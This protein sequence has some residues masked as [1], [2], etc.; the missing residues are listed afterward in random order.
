VGLD[1]LVIR[2]HEG[3]S[4]PHF[5][6]YPFSTTSWY[7]PLALRRGNIFI[8]LPGLASWSDSIGIKAT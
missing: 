5:S 8:Y 2:T 3:D 1:G 7:H 4:E 6:V